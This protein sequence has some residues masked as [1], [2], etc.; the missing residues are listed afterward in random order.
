M[1]RLTWLTNFDPRPTTL[2]FDGILKDILSLQ[3]SKF[4]SSKLP[5]VFPLPHLAYFEVAHLME[6]SQI[7]QTKRCHRR[8]LRSC[9]PPWSWVPFNG[10]A[11][12]Y[13]TDGVRQKMTLKR[14]YWIVGEITTSGNLGFRSPRGGGYS[15]LSWV[16][17]CGPK[18]RPPPYNKT[19]EDV[20][21]QPLSKPFV[22][23][24]GPFLNLAALF[25]M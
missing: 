8:F 19:R 14:L 11:P 12:F 1:S 21:L 24:R 3:I 18:F 5:L 6:H 13:K 15:T 23:W 17:L 2:N 16:R 25:T 9:I 7:L 20:N 22:S 4:L 10:T